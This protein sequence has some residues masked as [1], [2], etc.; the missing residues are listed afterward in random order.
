VE[1][2]RRRYYA[3]VEEKREVF[4]LDSDYLDPKQ[5]QWID[6]ELKTARDDWRSSTPSPALLERRPSTAR[7]S[8]CASRSSA[9]RE[10][11]RQRR[12]LRPRHIYERIKP[13]KGI[14]YFRV[15][16]GGQLRG[17]DLKKSR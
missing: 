5:L 8:I 12:L 14:Y 10:V 6:N 16:V 1:H 4:V 2:E 17:G 9:V 11:R 3:F 15:G 7:R 13:Q